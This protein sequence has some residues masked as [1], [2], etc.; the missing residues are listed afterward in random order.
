MTPRSAPERRDGRTN[1]QSTNSHCLNDSTRSFRT[2]SVS[3][4]DNSRPFSRYQSPRRLSPP[5]FTQK[6]P[7]ELPR[8]TEPTVTH[9]TK[10]TWTEHEKFRYSSS[11]ITLEHCTRRF[12]SARV[13]SQRSPSFSVVSKVPLNLKSIYS[14]FENHIE[15][16]TC[17]V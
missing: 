9:G 12:K 4:Y 17:P 15:V 14:L 7:T 10:G 8:P 3:G 13:F 16:I 1:G 2:D 6:R 5:R 11:P